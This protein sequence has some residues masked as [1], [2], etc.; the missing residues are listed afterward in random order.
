MAS[1]PKMQMPQM[2]MPMSMPG[3]KKGSMPVAASVK[4]M[5]PKPKKK[6]K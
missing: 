1:K 4:P 3:G 2:P 6:G 5:P